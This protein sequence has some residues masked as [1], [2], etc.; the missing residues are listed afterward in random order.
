LILDIRQEDV[1]QPKVLRP[2]RYDIPKEYINDL[3]IVNPL[4]QPIEFYLEKIV[5]KT[6]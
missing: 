2:I 5:E 4:S 1:N 6:E 3:E